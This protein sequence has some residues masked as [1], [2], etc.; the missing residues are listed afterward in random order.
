MIARR[1]VQS[2]V[3]ALA[4]LLTFGAAWSYW[5]TD[6]TGTGAGAAST[7]DR[8]SQP[9][10]TATDAAV[11]VTWA[12]SAL[13]DGGPVDGYLLV[14]Y[15]SGG[16]APQTMA[17]CAGTI[18]TTSCTESD[19]PVGSWE[20]AV[21]P[22]VGQHWRGTESPRSTPLVLEPSA[23][24]LG[25]AARFSVLGA[26]VTSTGATVVSGDLG[27]STGPASIAAPGIVGGDVHD[28]D[29][30]ARQ[31]RAD[32]L[33]AYDAARNLS[34]TDQ[35]WNGDVSQPLPPGVRHSAAAV[36]LTGTVTL[37]GGGDPGAV[38]VFQVDA[39][40]N[41]AAGTRLVLTNGATASNVVWQVQGAV[42]LG[43]STR[44][45][46]T[47][48]VSGS[49]TLGNEAQLIGRALATGT[50]TMAGNIVR[51]T[52]APPPAVTITGGPDRLSKQVTPTISGT[53][54][55]SAGRPVV[56]TIGQQTLTT[57]VSADLTWTVT[58]APLAAGVY[59]VVATV[60]DAAGN[61]GTATQQL[62][63]EINPAPLALG[64]ATSFSVLGGTGVVS[65]GAGTSLTG[66]VGVSPAG[67]ITGFAPGAVSGT[68]HERDALAADA[69]ADA[70]AAYDDADSRVPSSEFAGDQNGR[71][72]RPG[73]HH[74][75][76]AFALT[77]TLTF[78]A[79]GDPDAVFIVQ[80]DAA[81]NTAANSTMLLANGAQ[82][83]NVHWQVEGA[84]GPGATSTFIGTILTKGAVTLGNG[85]TLNGRALSV[86][87]VTLA[88]NVVTTP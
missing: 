34:A 35:S 7:V 14:R 60:R 70:G 29:A 74:T 88:N 4:T 68:T 12:P 33:A 23:V 83:A 2:L 51:F 3:V 81:L 56:V 67:T 17:S 59:T 28:G 44:F 54:T 15:E 18:T 75:S 62:T 11:T 16:I 80:V 48:L 64:Q 86:G 5:T 61:A 53:T 41:T 82:A 6:A 30:P 55:A 84:A 32:L 47:L 10:A 20:Y 66:N 22:I 40:L 85:A 78:D 21:V 24:P 25:S 38:F 13:S 63:A 43:A 52:D 36:N 27:A 69:Q 46:G 76:A 71:I 9:S 72:F 73:V 58:A 42:G 31:G 26:A 65:T 49:V 39:A 45:A 37:D 87:T 77:G 50:V 79:D 19:V 1:L 8:G 57:A